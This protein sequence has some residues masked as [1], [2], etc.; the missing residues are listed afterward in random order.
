MMNLI[1]GNLMS[2]F[3]TWANFSFFFLVC[4]FLRCDTDVGFAALDD[5]LLK[6]I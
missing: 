2:Y 4:S 5:T 1:L 3:Q 6:M